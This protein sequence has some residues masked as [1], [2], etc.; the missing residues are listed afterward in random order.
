M[1]YIH[2]LYKVYPYQIKN[3]HSNGS[4]G[5]IIAAG[6]WAAGKTFANAPKE[7]HA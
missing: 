5:G 3:I 6:V 2:L 1:F 4:I 7:T